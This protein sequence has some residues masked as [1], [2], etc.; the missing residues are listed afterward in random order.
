MQ[1]NHVKR[2]I[3]CALLGGVFW[4]FS[5]NCGEVL[6]AQY[7][8]P[9]M[10][11]TSVRAIIACILFLAFALIKSRPLLAR[12]LKDKKTLIRLVAFGV[13]GV[14][15][16]QS[17]YLAAIKY[18]GAGTALTLEQLN[19]VFVMFYVCL[20]ARRAPSKREIGGV[21]FAFI[22]VACIATQGDPSMLN[23][24]LI[25][26]L[27]GIA[28]AIA[29]A[30]YNLLPADALDKYG[31]PIVNGIGM[32]FAA[33]A[34]SLVSRPWEVE[35]H[36]DIAG[37]LIF[38]VGLGIIG[39]FVAYFLYIQGVKDAGPMRASLLACS[40]P[41]VGTFVSAVWVGTQVT[42]WDILG[43]VFIIAMVYLVSKPNTAQNSPS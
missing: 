14:L 19:L 33:L 17:T 34:S 40:E 35:V 25:G 2:G 36:L 9:V 37:I 22:G 38:V 12:V 21:V 43:L 26:F 27:W 42:I 6:M 5:G 28:A 23:M 16:M 3:L 30:F 41:V 13:L 20:R 7:G 39:T 8:V 29:T 11:L 18:A 32:F 1:N 4:G 31:T 10:W 24:Q 15:G